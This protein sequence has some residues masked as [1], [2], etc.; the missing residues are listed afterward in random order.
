MTAVEEDHVTD[1]YADV[2]TD[3]LLRVIEDEGRAIAES[4]DGADLTCPVSTCPGWSIADLIIHLATVYRWAR[5]I[6][7][8]RPERRPTLGEGA[9]VS[10]PAGDWPALRDAFLTAHGELVDA[11]RSAPPDMTCWTMWPA[12]S[13]RHYWV[14]RQA[15]E[16]LVHGVD[17]ARAVTGQAVDRPRVDPDIAADGVDEL[18]MGFSVRYRDRLRTP[19]PVTV[20]L[21]ATDADRGWWLRLGPAEPEFGRGEAADGD[22]TV[23]RGPAGRLMLSLWNR[24][25]WAGLDVTGSPEPLRMWRESARL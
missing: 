12:A 23:V 15:F 19:E 9:R 2:S 11:L 4:A 14:R 25:D 10:V 13:A 8:E 3:R 6:V 5:V 22:A 20:G 21:R 17:V 1:A 16:T 7:T 18:V 24:R